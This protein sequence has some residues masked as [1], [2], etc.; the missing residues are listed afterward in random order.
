MKFESKHVRPH[1]AR[2][3]WSFHV[4]TLEQRALLSA[5]AETFNLPSLEPLIVLAREGHD[6][7]PAA[8]DEVLTSLA[9]Q[10]TSGP[11][12]DLQSGTVDGN[13]FIS[14]VQSMESSYEQ[15]LNGALLP[16]FPNVD[17]L[18]I[19][20]GQRIV[21]DETAL[22]QQHAVGLLSSSDFTSQAQAAINSLTDGPLHSLSTP[23]SGYATGTQTFESNLSAIAAGLTA[24]TAITPAQA[25]ATMLAETVAYQADIHAAAQVIHPNVSNIVDQAVSGLISTADSIATDSSASDAATQITSAISTFDAAVLDTTGIFGP[26]GAIAISLATGRGF[27]PRTT[28][29]RASSSLTNVSGTASDGTATL[30]ATL[31]NSSGQAISGVSVSFTLDGAFAG[32]AETD[33]SGVATLTSVPTSDAAG[34][35]T[36]GVFAFSAGT[37]NDKSST[38]TGDLTVSSSLTATSLTAVS[39]TGATGG[40][41]TYT[42]TLTNSSTSAGI[43]GETI[44]FTVNGTSVGTATTNSS[45]VATL[46]GVANTEA[47]GTYT[48]DAKF[49]GN[50]TNSGS[51]GSGTLTVVQGTATSV[52][53][54]SG[55]GATGGTDTYTATL[56]NSSTSA[57]ISGETITFT[58]NGTSVG[59]AT[60]NSSGVATLSGVA[61]TEAAGTYTVDAKFA[62]DTT[63]SSSSGSGTLTVVQGTATSVTAVSGGATSGGTATLTAT[64]TN[65]STSAGI[66]NETVSFTLN[67]T[68]VGTT[69]TDSNGVATLM[70]V[71]NTEPSGTYP[72]AVVAN[73][74]GDSTYSSSSGTGTLTV[75]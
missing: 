7:A 63:N 3:R 35:D 71:A 53:A 23:L 49:A 11:L 10:L 57:G 8:I 56:T 40:T 20:Q 14:E 34:T 39:G 45:G 25:S 62:G 41:D 52:T 24:S 37:I 19:L 46:S 55:S 61:N 4:E 43:S 30:T 9:S 28:D 66:P 12:A 48:V 70:G 22:N 15:E 32:V 68:P 47:A 33:S 69:T 75:T 60:T 36:N 13:G 54:V 64:L 6:T 44:T 42:S 26:S 74:A 38:A 72:N 21:A 16:E 29:Y 17:T 59:T 27:A 50:T 51:S 18:L 73:F 31:T 58:V 1:R 2:R 5:S 67:G 65:S